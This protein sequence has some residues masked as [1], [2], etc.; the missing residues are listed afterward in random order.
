[1]MPKPTDSE[2]KI[3]AKAANHTCGLASDSQ[4]GEKKAFRPS[5]AP[6]RN[7][8]RTTMMRKRTTSRGKNTLF[9]ASTPRAIPR[10][11]I[12]RTSTQMRTRGTATAATGSQEN[13]SPGTTRKNV[14]V[15][16]DVGSSPQLW[17]TEYTMYWALQAMTAP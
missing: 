3:C 9:A 12:A 11:M 4:C 17:F 15:K 10:P 7:R 8:A 1:M 13:W 16:K 14:S 5:A 6:G 2:K